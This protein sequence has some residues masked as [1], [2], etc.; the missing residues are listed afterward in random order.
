MAATSSAGNAKRQ[1]IQLGR[2]ANVF[3]A[4]IYYN[5]ISKRLDAAVH[6]PRGQSIPDVNQLLLEHSNGRQPCFPHYHRRRAQ[7]G[8][9]T[10]T[11]GQNEI[12]V[13][14]INKAGRREGTADATVLEAAVTLCRIQEKPC[15]LVASMAEDSKTKLQEEMKFR[16]AQEPKAEVGLRIVLDNLE[17]PSSVLDSGAIKDG[18]T[19]RANNA[20]VEKSPLISHSGANCSA[21]KGQYSAHLY[22]ESALDRAPIMADKRP[23]GETLRIAPAREQVRMLARDTTNARGIP[24]RQV[25]LPAGNRRIR[26][27]FQRLSKQFWLAEH[28][29]HPSVT[30]NAESA[31]VQS[32]PRRSAQ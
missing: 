23:S 4:V 19:S 18:L 17:R 21:T 7:R 20:A 6:V 25:H 13:E 22:R 16:T 9:R 8:R 28:H 32:R 29:G 31:P 1:A 14:T 2:E 12:P 26:Q 5:P 30:L 10:S 15:H 11:P 24:A 27:F 3:S